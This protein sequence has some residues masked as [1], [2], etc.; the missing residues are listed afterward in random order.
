MQF[1][2]DPVQRGTRAPRGV[3]LVEVAILMALLSFGL[4]ALTTTSQ[5]LGAYRLAQDEESA[6]GEAIA[7]KV[8]EVSSVA[9]SARIGA[10]NW[11]EATTSRFAHGEA[12][13]QSFRVPG[14]MPWDG[15]SA[16]GSVRAI[17][18]ETLTDDEIGAAL[19]MPQDLDSDGAIE[20]TDV[21]ASADLLPF[22]VRVRWQG[23]GGR[24]ELSHAFYATRF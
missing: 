17:V 13:Q 19:G 4:L 6:A 16:V 5:A 3:T 7:A 22:V 10:A 24:R 18:D 11:S 21:S 2:R 8:R 12:R 20:N 1:H 9:A 14:L 15:E 23:P